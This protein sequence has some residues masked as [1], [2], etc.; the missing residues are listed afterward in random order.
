MDCDCSK[1]LDHCLNH[2][3]SPKILMFKPKGKIM[4]FTL[5]PAPRFKILSTPLNK[6]LGF[7]LIYKKPGRS[8]SAQMAGM[9]I[10]Q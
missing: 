4:P 1:M 2:L 9:F 5:L 10:V 8:L 6:V 7:K 3:N